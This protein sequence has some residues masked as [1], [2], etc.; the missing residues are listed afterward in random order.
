MISPLI[1]HDRK[2]YTSIVDRIISVDERQ[3]RK[4]IGTQLHYY[5]RY[6]RRL[7]HGS[8]SNKRSPYGLFDLE[9]SQCADYY[10]NPH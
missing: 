7:S 3:R 10:F 4:H 5:E 2:Q 6:R 8:S 1:F 9:L